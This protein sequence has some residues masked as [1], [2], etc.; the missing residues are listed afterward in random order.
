MDAD[1]KLVV[2]GMILAGYLVL[3]LCFARFWVKTRDRLFVW[4]AAAFAVL[5]IE[6]VLLI[7]LRVAHEPRPEIYLVRLCAFALIAV[8][9]I[10]KNRDK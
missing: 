5:A 6:R 9:I 1:L 4:F 2:S 7:W 10:D 8:A 3:T